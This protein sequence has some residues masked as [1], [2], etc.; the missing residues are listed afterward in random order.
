MYHVLLQTPKTVGRSRGFIP[1]P[2]AARATLCRG[3]AAALPEEV[4]EGR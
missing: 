3:E 4:E 1:L 2:P